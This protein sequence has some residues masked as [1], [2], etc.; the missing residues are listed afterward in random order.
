MMRRN[1]ENAENFIVQYLQIIIFGKIAIKFINVFIFLNSYEYK[2]Y[3][4]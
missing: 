3:E 2:I 1:V 4:V